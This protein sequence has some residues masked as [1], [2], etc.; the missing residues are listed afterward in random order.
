MRHAIGNSAF[1]GK[2]APAAVRRENE[3]VSQRSSF[4]ALALIVK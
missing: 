4:M 2:T 1:P 3:K